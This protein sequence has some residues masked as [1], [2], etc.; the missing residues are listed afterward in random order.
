[1][2][3]LAGRILLVQRT[4]QFVAPDT[5]GEVPVQLK[6]QVPDQLAQL[7]PQ[8]IGLYPYHPHL[9][10]PGGAPVSET[11][12]PGHQDPAV[13]QGNSHQVIVI[14]TPQKQGI[15]THHPQPRG[16]PS[17]VDVNNKTRNCRHEIST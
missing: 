16:Q 12:I 11:G 15:V 4:Q 5:V 10:V 6:L 3:A 17:Y 9:S 13:P 1:M 2:G 14:A 7:A 8:V